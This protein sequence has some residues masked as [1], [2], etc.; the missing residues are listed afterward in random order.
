MRVGRFT[1]CLPLRD[2]LIFSDIDKNIWEQIS[3]APHWRKTSEPLNTM[4]A[5]FALISSVER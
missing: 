1:A 3:A 2:L 4:A 5:L